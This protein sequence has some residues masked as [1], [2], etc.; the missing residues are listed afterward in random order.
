MRSTAG[1]D[2]PHVVIIMA[3]H[4]R[5]D[6]IGEYTPN[7]R[8][9]QS[10]SVVFERAYCASPLCVPA[11]GSFFTGKYPNVTGSLNNAK[12]A[13]DREHGFVRAEH[14]TLYELME[15][16]WDSW[17]TG[18]QNLYTAKRIDRQPETKTRWLRMEGR[19]E[20]F[21]EQHNKRKPGGPRFRTFIPEAVGG[22]KVT[23][24]AP[25]SIPETGCYEEGF[26]YFVDGFITRDTLDAIRH[27]DPNKPLLL[28]AMYFAP[29]PPFDIPEPWYSKIRD[30][31]M[32]DNVGVWSAAQSPLQM[33]N[34]PGLVGA[35]YQRED[36][37]RI[38]DV[39]MGYV[40]LFDDCVGMIVE[41]LKRQG[42]YDDTLLIFTSDH[43][44]ML[45]AHCLW[46]KM[47]MYEESVRIPLFMKF[48]STF[49]AKANRIAEPVS[50]VDVLPTVCDYLGIDPPAGMCGTSLMP[51]IRGER[52]DRGA[53]FIQYDGNGSRSSLQRCI[54][55]GE[56]KLTVDMFKDETY[57]EL[58][59]VTEDPME[60][61]NLAF[62][63]NMRGMVE[64]LLQQLRLHMER[65]GD[66]VVM[67]SGVYD[68][69]IETYR[70]LYA[71]T[72]GSKEPER[73]KGA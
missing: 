1:A 26:D 30:V 69:F 68:Q 22:G 71:S 57:L 9:L 15:H 36:W 51:A 48:P 46:Q 55:S 66:L 7:I 58:Y 38:W 8:Q 41:E 64:S 37:Q 73:G 60:L 53:L 23:R 3:D 31:P 54:V 52:I 28:N 21:L 49:G 45:G 72:S 29:H 56:Y 61:H 14:E 44:E 40:A 62:D 63:P 24:R 17:H 19:Y 27:R 25:C 4:L 59:R 6:A 65:T 18:K 39:Y 2:K 11:R 5:I 34:L 32:P 12:I 42:I 10:E 13:Q 35:R 47:C 16:D 43:G 70:E 50:A 33:Y 67:P 20:S